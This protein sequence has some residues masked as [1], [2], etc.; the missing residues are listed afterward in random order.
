MVVTTTPIVPVRWVTR[1]R[2]AALARYPDSWA[3][4]LIRSAVFALIEGWRL[5]ARETVECETFA[6][7]AMSLMDARFTVVHTCACVT[8]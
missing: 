3:M 7:L 2:A 1:L 8:F 5:S 4:R 6:S